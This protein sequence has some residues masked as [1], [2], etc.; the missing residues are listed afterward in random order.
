[1]I[2]VI[3]VA[4]WLMRATST[5]ASL[6]LSALTVSLM[7]RHD[8]TERMAML[9]R[10]NLEDLNSLYETYLLFANCVLAW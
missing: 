6:R 5:I 3:G 1:M 4:G 2:T 10:I 8:G 7:L 9:Y